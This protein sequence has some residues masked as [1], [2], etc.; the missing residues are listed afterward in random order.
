MMMEGLL[1][2]E[3]QVIPSTSPFLGSSSFPPSR[4]LSLTYHNTLSLRPLSSVS[5]VPLCPSIL[6]S[7]DP[8]LSL[9]PQVSILPS[10]LP[11]HRLSVP[12]S[13]DPPHTFPTCSLQVP[14]LASA[15]HPAPSHSGGLAR[16]PTLQHVITPP[17]TVLLK[18]ALF[19]S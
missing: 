2:A 13:S 6:R 1:N 9:R 7:S 8:L 18:P 10:I 3:V 15:S 5:Q 17:I 12:P 19:P 4:H 11:S 16:M 14:L